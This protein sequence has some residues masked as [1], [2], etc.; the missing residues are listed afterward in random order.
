MGGFRRAIA[1]ASCV[2]VAGCGAVTELPVPPPPP[3]PHARSCAWTELYHLA[4]PQSAPAS[5]ITD[6]KNLFFSDN[7]SIR[8]MPISGGDAS[9][10]SNTPA[11]L[12]W[13]SGD[14][15]D[16][17]N[18]DD[19]LWQV[20]LTGGTA[21]LIADGM[22]AF[23]EPTLAQVGALAFDGTFLY[24]DLFPQKGPAFWRLFRMPVAGGP[25]EQIA[26]LPV[27]DPHVNW[28]ALTPTPQ[29]L[30]V[31]FENSP[32]VGAY[33]V[34][35]GGQPMALPSAP[36]A[37]GSV[38]NAY[39][40][41]GPGG[42]LW[43]TN[44]WNTPEAAVVTMSLTDLSNP[45]APVW[46]PFWPDRPSSVVS[47]PLEAFPGDGDSWIIGAYELFDDGEYHADLWSVDSGGTGVRLGCDPSVGGS[48]PGIVNAVLVTPTFVYALVGL[49]PESEFHYAIV[50]MPR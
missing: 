44:V 28:T 47:E 41:N 9:I 10:V 21:T 15:I 12:M 35:P 7:G 45:G 22:T 23:V 48:G 46:R 27:P 16:F 11:Y 36:Q 31:A 13:L 1:V 25:A 37:G 30:L 26:E 34:P 40:G 17:A 18:L 24:W 5:L 20:P 38:D 6:G 4:F 8:S 33:L 32:D 14:A 39:V 2:G 29:G 50:R 3:P 49:H 43:N 42:V 19:K